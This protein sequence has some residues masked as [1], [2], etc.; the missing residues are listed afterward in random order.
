[1]KERITSAALSSGQ[2][3][4]RAFKLQLDKVYRW[5]TVAF[6]LFVALLAVL[7]QWGLPREWI[8]FMF[9]FATIGVYAAIGI[10]SRTTDAT[11]YYVAGRRVPAIY[12]GDRKSVV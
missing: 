11:E 9:L 7:E 12:N 5:Y 2:A 3:Y 1:M 4:K 8:G 6:F 10:M